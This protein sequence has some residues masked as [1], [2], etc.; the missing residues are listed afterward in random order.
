[1]FSL[2][3]EVSYALIHG[4]FCLVFSILSIASQ[5]F[6]YSVAYWFLSFTM[7]V[8]VLFDIVI[9]IRA[10]GEAE[11]KEL[12][13]LQF[14]LTIQL[15]FMLF[16]MLISLMKIWIRSMKECFSME[17]VRRIDINAIILHAI[18]IM[19]LGLSLSAAALPFI[20]SSLLEYIPLESKE[21]S[22][23]SWDPEGLELAIPSSR[24]YK[25]IKDELTFSSYELE[26]VPSTIVLQLSL[27]SG[28]LWIALCL[29]LMYY[30]WTLFK[31]A[32]KI[33]DY[34]VMDKQS[35]IITIGGLTLFLIPRGIDIILRGQVA[36]VRLASDICT[37]LCLFFA[38]LP[39]RL[40]D[41]EL[42]PLAD[43]V[44]YKQRQIR[45]R[46]QRR[47]SRLPGR[48]RQQRRKV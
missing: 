15:T 1:M 27:W 43:Y 39:R 24:E 3:P 7:I 40:I 5:C 12:D 13:I 37:G 9:I 17:F 6:Y 8:T 30:S 20:D 31:R 41:F 46:Q 32:S 28:I 47:Q 44:L 10:T 35:Q 48:R 4:I 14:I 33:T 23:M 34:Y 45:R 25:D 11:R 42:K 18:N 21:K 22:L 29:P 38:L 36:K 26:Q 2:K 16:A 19:S